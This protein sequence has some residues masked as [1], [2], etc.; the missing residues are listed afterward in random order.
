MNNILLCRKNALRSSVADVPSVRYRAVS[1]LPRGRSLTI[2][3]KLGCDSQASNHT[4]R[5]LV[6]GTLIGAAL[7]QLGRP[8]TAA[9][10]SEMEFKEQV[11]CDADCEKKLEAVDSVST[12]SGLKYKDIV[13]GKGPSPPTGY[14]VTLHYVAMTP[15]GQIFANSYESGKP[16]DVRV[17][18]GQIVAGLDEG[19]KTMKVG[20][21]RRIYVPG[22]L[23]FP[24][25]LASAPGRPRIPPNS[26]VVFDVD[27]LYIPGLEAD[28]EDYE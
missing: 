12:P 20:G 25:G 8:H 7:F 18:A 10:M 19:L 5:G 13:E 1:P 24:K 16:Y 15:D 26:P 21:K 4:R 17:G 14:Q 27:L 23:S 22:N 2:S 11:V 9:A 6:Q 3:S 28:D